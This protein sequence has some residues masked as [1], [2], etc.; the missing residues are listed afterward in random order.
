MTF[1]VRDP[2]FHEII[3]P[4][5]EFEAI[6]TGLKITEGIIWHPTD[7]YLIFSDM[8]A[9]V[10]YKWSEEE[11]LSILKKPSNITNGNFVDRQ[12]RIVSCEHAT[13][14]VS[15]I[16]TDG[17]YIRVLATHYKGK[18][19]NSP[20]DIVVDSKDRI[21]FTDP[22][23]GRKSPAVGV[24]RECQLDFQGVFRLDPDGSL[25]LVADDFVQPNGL[26]FLPGE[27][28][29][30]I[31]DTGKEHIR[32]FKVNA[33]GSLSGG[34]VLCVV[35][36]EGPGKPDGMKVDVQGRIYCN[37]PGGV[38]ILSSEGKLLGIIKTPEQSRNFCFGGKDHTDFF[39]AASSKI[40]RVR[41]R[42]KGVPAFS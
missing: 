19:L 3:D 24:A 6:A 39:I 10:V 11:K 9:G 28:T 33:D 20:N 15:R 29:L 8:G 32:R 7:N 1:D 31:N 22:T 40:L 37:G 17:R 35:S 4:K 34:E 5:A 2:T 26:C 27:A 12:G 18:E 30:L 36:G 23:Y 41:T 42:T 16:E 38:H 14:C 25:T 21:W 13:S